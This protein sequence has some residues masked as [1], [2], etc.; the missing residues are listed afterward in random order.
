MDIQEALLKL[1]KN[2]DSQWTSDGVPLV[3]AISKIM[4]REVT[5]SEIVNAAPTFSRQDARIQASKEEHPPI[6]PEAAVEGNDPK[7]P[8]DEWD[9]SVVFVEDQ[10]VGMSL[11]EVAQ[12]P[13]LI[14]RALVEL[15]R[16]NTILVRRKNQ[17]EKQMAYVGKLTALMEKAKSNYERRAKIKPDQA[18]IRG[19]LDRQNE[20]RRERFNRAQRFIEA[21]TSARDVAE[22]LSTTSKIDAA[23]AQRKPDRGAARPAHPRLAST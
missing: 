12:D 23:L 7:G 20:A 11:S 4:G 13:A 10:V 22:Q 18:P 2:D 8:D 1:D 6:V 21:G 3:A 19:Y 15:N 17:A 9:A 14:D 5:R 16:Q